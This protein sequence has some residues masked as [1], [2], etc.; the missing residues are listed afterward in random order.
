MKTNWIKSAGTI[1]LAAALVTGMNAQSHRQGGNG[2]GHYGKRYEKMGS[3]FSLDLTEAQQEQMTTLRTNH[4]KVM[5]PLKNKMVELKASE[6]TL[7]SEEQVDIKTV[8]KSIDAQTDLL[9]KMH[10]L[11]VQQKLEMKNILTDE[12]QMKL[13][14]RRNFTKHRRG[15]GSDLHRGSRSGGQYRKNRLV[16]TG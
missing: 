3:H 15:K 11:Q 7:L 16:I 13:D 6:R 1:I 14:Q 5:K 12:Q 9:N 4:Y 10:K 8:N 2:T